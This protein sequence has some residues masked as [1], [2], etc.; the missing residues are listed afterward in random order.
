LPK[1]KK[2][3]AQKVVD[4]LWDEH[5]VPFPLNV[6]EVTKDPPCDTL[7]F[8]DSRIRTA[9]VCLEEGQTFPEGV[10][11][12]VLDRVGKMSGPLKSWKP[13]EKKRTGRVVK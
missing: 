7:H 6:G 13:T 10:K 5:L 2:T 4:Q 3:E 8:H 12:A 1:T 11:D 9:D